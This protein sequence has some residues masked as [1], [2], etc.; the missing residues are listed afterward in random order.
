MVF[1]VTSHVKHNYCN[2]VTASHRSAALLVE[3]NITRRLAGCEDYS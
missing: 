3:G 1:A 2:A